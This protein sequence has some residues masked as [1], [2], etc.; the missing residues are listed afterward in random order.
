MVSPL[1]VTLVVGLLLWPLLFGETLFYR[2]LYRQYFGTAQLIHSGGLSSGLLWDSLVNGGQPLLANPNRFLLYPTRL[3]YVLMSPLS[4]I[5]WEITLHFLF[6][7][8][9][10]VLLARRLGLSAAGSSVTGIAYAIG[11]LSIS[12][13]NHLGRF[14][15]FHWLPWIVLAAHAGFA[16]DG[17]NTHRWRMAL[18]WMIAVQWLTGAAEIAVIAALTVACWVGVTEGARGRFKTAALWVTGLIVLGGLLAAI[19]ILPAAE[20]VLQS[21]RTVHAE[22]DALLTWSLHP[23]RMI[24]CVVPGFCGPVDVADPVS[25]YWGANLVDFGFPYLVSLYLGASVVL[26]A[27]MGWFRSGGDRRWQPMRWLLLSLTVVGLVVACGRFLPIVGRLLAVTPGIDLL[28]YPVKAVLLAGLP[29]AVLAG[30]G[31]HLVVTGDRP[32]RVVFIRLAAGAGAVALVVAGIVAAGLADWPLRMIFVDGGA[33]AAA[34]IGWRF[35]HAGLAMMGLAMAAMIASG[36]VRAVLIVVVVAMDLLAAAAAG[37]PMG[38]REMFQTPP[39]LAEQ[40]RQ[41][42]RNGKLVR[43]HDPVSIQVPLVENRAWAPAAWWYSIVNGAQG[44]NWGLPMVYHSDAEVL[45][46]RRMAELARMVWELEWKDRLSLFRVAG[47]EV[48]LTPKQIPIGGVERLDVIPTPAPGLAYGVYR[49]EDVVP[50]VWLVGNESVVMTAAEALDRLLS[51]DFDVEHDV[52]RER[53]PVTTRRLPTALSR[54]QPK[55][56]LWQGLIDVPSEG[57]MV[58]RFPWHQDILVEVDG[59]QV[60][61]ERLNYAFTGARIPSGSH[62]VRVLFAPR[63]LLVGVVISM[64][65][66][67][68]WI[69]AC[70]LPWIRS[71]HPRRSE[72]PR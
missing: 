39:P 21:E 43:D 61:A 50:P 46:G 37:L 64:A 16:Q 35:L 6:G 67:F 25:E 31:V 53:D 28:R 66:V 58:T 9:G 7:G 45:A 17:P 59:Q 13:G 48:I 57:L 33:P 18:P 27:V 51:E 69:F 38:P 32:L 41:H 52:V 63:S 72:E 56:E 40:L 15:A 68:V 22:S 60:E 8:I 44:A 26:L 42:L 62:S 36:R 29:V 71:R 34:G 10:A 65:S 4:G 11:G 49:V 47:V 30:R 5:N 2:D 20:M 12:L 1:V 23:L 14:L 54:L 3:L 70:C 55:T 19:Q 24:E